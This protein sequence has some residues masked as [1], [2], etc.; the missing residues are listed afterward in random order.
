MD[1]FDVL[2]SKN[3]IKGSSEFR[4]SIMKQIPKRQCEVFERPTQLSRL[5]R[6]QVGSGMFCTASNMDTQYAQ[7][8]EEEHVD[9]FQP[10]R[11]KGEKVASQ[12]LMRVMTQ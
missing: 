3:P 12:Y 11:F 2:R 1:D 6:N 7:F 9:R 5:L 4:V 10:K 8:N